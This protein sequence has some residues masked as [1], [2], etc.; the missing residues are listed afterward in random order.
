MNNFMRCVYIFL[1]LAI[2]IFGAASC[3]SD[4]NENGVSKPA[5]ATPTPTPEQLLKSLITVDFDYIYEIRR[6][7]GQPLTTADIEFIAERTDHVNRRLKAKDDSAVF[8][9][10]NF[11]VDKK[12]IAEIKNRF[13]VADYSKSEEQIKNQKDQAKKQSNKNAE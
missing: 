10:S 11:M 1:L 8:I 2:S 9:G 12:A 4:A 3:G 5:D 13:A 6:K 7:D